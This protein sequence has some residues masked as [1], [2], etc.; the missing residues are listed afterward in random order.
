MFLNVIFIIIMV[1]IVQYFIISLVKSNSVEN[2]T[3][4]LNKFYLSSIS[5]LIIGFIYVLMIDFTQGYLTDPNYYISLAI[6]IGFLIYAYKAQLFVNDYYWAN[7]MIE[8]ESDGLMISK[9]MSEQKITNEN[10]A[11]CVEFAKYIVLS[12]KEQI[13]LLKQLS[14]NSTTK[15]LFC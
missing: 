1:F 5:A 6:G 12:Q 13:E 9:K 11:K 7:A 4:N 2:I 14:N 15:G 8:L 10:Q 3:N